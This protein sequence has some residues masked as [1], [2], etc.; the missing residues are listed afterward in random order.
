MSIGPSYK[1][2]FKLVNY[3]NIYG[4][5]PYI[6]QDLNGY[7]HMIWQSGNYKGTPYMGAGH[8]HTAYSKDG[9][10]WKPANKAQAF[11]NNITLTDMETWLMLE[12]EKGIKYY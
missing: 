11:D 2:P 10:N 7:F 5:D 1:G 6:W 3:L 8:W 9:F 12:E 4:E